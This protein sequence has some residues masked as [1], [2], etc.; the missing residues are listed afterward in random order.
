M[1]DISLRHLP[2]DSQTDSSLSFQIPL[3][4]S[5]ADLLLADNNDD[6]LKDDEYSFTTPAP[7]RMALD[8][9]L[10]LSQLTP[11]LRVASTS[12]TQA[13]TVSPQLHRPRSKSPEILSSRASPKATPMCTPKHAPQSS[14]KLVEKAKMGN[15]V[16]MA[17]DS[18]VSAERF[19]NL[20]AE[21][22]TL[23]STE[24]DLEATQ[25]WTGEVSQ[26]QSNT[27]VKL[28]NHIN[29]KTKPVRHNIMSSINLLM[30]PDQTIAAG[31]VTKIAKNKLP[32]SNFTRD[33]N[34]ASRQ[35]KP[36]RLATQ[37]M[38]RP[39]T[40]KS[41]KKTKQLSELGG[42][43]GNSSV[44]ATGGAAGRLMMYGAKLMTDG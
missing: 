42:D 23:V 15:E 3:A 44:G 5:S 22:D 39:T 10:T 12:A 6:F 7:R 13:P 4:D 31:G 2:D 41:D 28:P 33:V 14:R 32:R 38:I 19:A 25:S 29:P 40:I 27:A 35:I 30:F 26:T 16:F 43:E 21:V 36:T 11:T 8:E 34:A 9:P 37:K 20:K 24:I 1:T 17:V 18:P